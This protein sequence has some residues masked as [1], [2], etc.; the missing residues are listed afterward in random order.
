[1][2]N[3]SIMKIKQGREAENLKYEGE[4]EGHYPDELGF[5]NFQK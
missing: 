3:Q 2:T 5:K 4:C 1:M